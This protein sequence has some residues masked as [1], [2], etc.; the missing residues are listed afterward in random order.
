VQLNEE[1]AKARA[2]AVASATVDAKTGEVSGMTLD[3][4]RVT[5]DRG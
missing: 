2:D 4:E 3:L 5:G 1:P